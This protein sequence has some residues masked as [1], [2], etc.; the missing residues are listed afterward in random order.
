MN[1][2]EPSSTILPSTLVLACLV[3]ALLAG[4]SSSPSERMMTYPIRGGKGDYSIS[5][6]FMESPLAKQYSL[7]LD[8][9]DGGIAK[10]SLSISKLLFDREV[11]LSE[12]LSRGVAAYRFAYSGFMTMENNRS[13]LKLRVDDRDYELQQLSSRQA[14][15]KAATRIDVYYSLSPELVARLGNAKSVSLQYADPILLDPRQLAMLKS[16]LADTE[17]L[18]YQSLSAQAKQAPADPARRAATMSYVAGD[19]PG[20]ALSD[21]AFNVRITILSTMPGSGG[22]HGLMLAYEAENVSDKDARFDPQ[23]FEILGV[24]T[25]LRYE[26]VGKGQTDESYALGA[27]KKSPS[28]VVNYLGRSAQLAKQIKVSMGK[29]SVTLDGSAGAVQY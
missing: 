28:S 11:T 14:A 7:R 17:S 21:G 3:G 13:I 19:G 26:A 23:A 1:K 10:E 6:D 12:D 24:D 22:L 18:S 4:C 20:V 29:A 16:F 8:I 15:G 5:C 2:N 9:I 25:G 27:G